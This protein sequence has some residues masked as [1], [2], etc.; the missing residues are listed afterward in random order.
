[1]TLEDVLSDVVAQAVEK[2]FAPYLRRLSD[3]EPLVYNVREAAAVLRTSE[4]TIR[5]M[6]DTGVLPV[7]PHMGNRVVIPRKA[8]VHLVEAGLPSSDTGR[9]PEPGR[10]QSD[11]A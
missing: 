1:V 5:N 11:V 4:T 7:V 2:A 3:P 6:I 10:W 9:Q 8:V